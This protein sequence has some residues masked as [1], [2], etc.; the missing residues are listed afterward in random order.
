MQETD[1]AVFF[2][3]PDFEAVPLRQMVNRMLEEKKGTTVLGL[4]GRNDG[5]FYVLGSRTDDMRIC[6]KELNGLLNG[7]G[8]GSAQMAQGTF[9][10]QEKVLRAVLKEKGF[11]SPET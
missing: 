8:G 3:E 4:S 9:F 5:Y 10:T 11:S 6:S 1:G 2:V 7:R